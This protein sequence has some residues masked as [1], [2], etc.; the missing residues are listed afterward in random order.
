MRVSILLKLLAILSLVVSCSK[1]VRQLPTDGGDSARPSNSKNFKIGSNPAKDQFQIITPNTKTKG[2]DD[3]VDAQKDYEKAV[4]NSK[5][6]II[7]EVGAAGLSFDDTME[8]AQSILSVADFTVDNGGTMV[9]GYKEGVTVYYRK[10]DPKVP[11]F[12]W[13]DKNY[14]GEMKIGGEIGNLRMQSDISAFFNTSTSPNGELFVNKFYS[15]VENKEDGFD[16][17]AAGACG[18][19][20]FE[21]YYLFIIGKAYFL[22]SKDRKLIADIRLANSQDAGDFL[23]SVDILNGEFLIPEKEGIKVGATYE[24]IKSN[25]KSTGFMNTQRASFSLDIEDVNL[26]FS[27]SQFDRD[28]KK[29]SAEETLNY[30]YLL[31][32]FTNPIPTADGE[33]INEVILG[34]SKLVISKDLASGKTVVGTVPATADLNGL[35][36]SPFTLKPKLEAADQIDFVK[37]FVKTLKTQIEMQTS[38]KVLTKIENLF[39]TKSD[40]SYSISVEAVDEQMGKGFGIYSQFNTLLSEFGYL[41]Y[42]KLTKETINK[43]VLAGML[44]DIDFSG[45]SALTSFAGFDIGEAV[46]I[47]DIDN[48]REE[49]TYTLGEETQRVAFSKND[50]Q[51]GV[52]D[53]LT[54]ET[55]AVS[56]VSVSDL[57][58]GLSLKKLADGGFKVSEISTNSFMGEIK[59]LCGYMGS[60]ASE[61]PIKAGMSDMAMSEVVKNKLSADCN[62]IVYKKGDGSGR[63]GSIY[64]PDYRLKLLFGSR[65]LKTISIYSNPAEVQ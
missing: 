9:S 1:G 21:K 28:Y 7:Y 17:I 63:I 6:D 60:S 42:G 26:G 61:A 47:S 5:K 37:S 64:F 43:K 46:A 15:A 30:F 10:Q 35:S 49:A 57:G 2:F 59:G 25:T 53:G 40:K 12:M 29:P 33:V 54:K 14:L 18:I 36:A 22:V 65:E 58:V 55:H 11:V 38:Y 31:P 34:K 62:V 51:F 48:A 3:S 45:A 44:S 20:Q 16:C 52:Y 56:S 27:K 23:T 39:D 19:K 4:N 50:L 41:Y 8:D 24:F 13:L 32:N